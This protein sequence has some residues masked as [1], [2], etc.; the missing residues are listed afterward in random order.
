MTR[1]RT[2]TPADIAARLAG[3]TPHE[4]LAAARAIC[5]EIEEP[6]V[7][8][9]ADAL[10]VQLAARTD[11]DRA[12][13]A[14][15][16][17]ELPPS[18][19]GCYLQATAYGAAGLHAEA[20][21]RWSGFFDRCP[22]QDPVLMA[23]RARALSGTGEWDAAARHLRQALGTRPSYTFYARFGRLVDEVAAHASG[24]IRQARIAVL[25]SSTTSLL[26][27][28]LRASVSATASRRC[29]T[30]GPSAPSGRRSSSVTVR[31]PHSS[32]RS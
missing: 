7:P 16:I 2:L 11:D 31:S 8:A 12:A 10:L 32:R 6:F 17:D 21:E 4:R 3:L 29:S 30:K 20:A 24:A 5:D 14:Q 28:V 23:H 25:G 22:S 26:I 18:T 13:L 1:P 15:W 9:T 19:T 27:P